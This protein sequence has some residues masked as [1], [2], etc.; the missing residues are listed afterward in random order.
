[1]TDS[2]VSNMRFFVSAARRLLYFRFFQLWKIVLTCFIL[3]SLTS[4]LEKTEDR[5]I[6]MMARFDSVFL[7]RIR[8]HALRKGVWFRVLNR[9]ERAI[10]YLVP[11][12]METPRSST[13]IDMLAKIVVKI[14]NALQS[15]V[16]ILTNQVG[17]P[18][19]KTF[20]QIALQWGHKTAAGWA[21][22]A[23]FARY[24]AIVNMNNIRMFR[25]L[26]IGRDS[27]VSSRV[28]DNEFG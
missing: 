7:L 15:S 8:A 27:R 14:K 2:F 12:C 13:L 17:K 9:A 6:V 19:A 1:M 5:C 16:A 21:E 28:V 10:L 22:N 11:R 18:L 3:M 25:A 4:M 24:L 20:S 26:D 23:S